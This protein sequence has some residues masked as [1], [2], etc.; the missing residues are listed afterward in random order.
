M[1]NGTKP[2]LRLTPARIIA[3]GF[4]GVILAGT[5]LLMLPFA[6]TGQNPFGFLDALFTATSAVCVTGLSTIDPGNDLTVF[7]QIVMIFLMQIG[8]LGITT[9]GIGVIAFSRKKITQK[10]TLIVKEA[11]NYP[12]LMGIGTMVKHMLLLKISLASK[13]I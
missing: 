13:R 10:E 6:Q 1:K 8:G 12:T 11:I 4:C 3:L 2:L 9:I 7:G 5:V